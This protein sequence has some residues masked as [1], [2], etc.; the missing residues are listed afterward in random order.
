MGLGQPAGQSAAGSGGHAGD[1][2]H[3]FRAEVLDIAGKIFKAVR[4]VPDKRFIKKFFGNNDLT[5][6]QSQGAVGAGTDGQPLGPVDFGRQRAP[7]VDDHQLG[8]PS[9]GFDNSFIIQRRTVGGRI[10]TPDHDEFGLFQVGEHVDK[11]AAHG[12]VGGDHGHGDVAEG[13]DA[14]GVGRAEGKEHAGS[15]RHGHV[16]GLK[17]VAHG[18][19]KAAPAGID[20]RGLGTMVGLDGLE[21]VDNFIIGLVPG[22]L[23]KFKGA[24]GAF[25]F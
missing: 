25:S 15:R 7:G 10:G 14:H 4:P 19:F 13:P 22:Y 5:Q 16:L 23:L 17:D 12:D 9:H 20:G 1:A 21:P 11:H 6:G 24:F 2:F 18:Q 8:A 3:H